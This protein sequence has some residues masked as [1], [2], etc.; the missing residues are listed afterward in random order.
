MALSQLGMT[1]TTFLFHRWNQRICPRIVRS[2]SVRRGLVHTLSKLP[3]F[4][5]PLPCYQDG[6]MA[7]IR[8]SH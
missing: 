6:E 8:G 2:P 3:I 4:V 5:N 7:C 1:F